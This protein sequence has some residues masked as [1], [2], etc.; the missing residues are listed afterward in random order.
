MVRCP[1]TSSHI[2]LF[3]YLFFHRV[4]SPAGSSLLHSLSRYSRYIGILD[5]DN[6]TLRCPAYKGTLLGH[7]ADHRTQIK[8]GSTYYLHVQSVLTQLAAKAFL[9]TFCHHLYLPI[10]TDQDAGSVV[11]RRTNFLLQLG[12]TE[13][14]SKIIRFLSEL[15]KQH[16]LQGPLKGVS[17]S[18]FSFSYTTSYLYK[19]WIWMCPLFILR[20]F[21]SFHILC[22]PFLAPL[23]KSG[24]QEILTVFDFSS[25]SF[26]ASVGLTIQFVGRGWPV[27]SVVLNVSDD[28]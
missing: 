17:Q 16:Y 20:S 24:D 19:I 14:E 1:Q 11:L 27:I 22:F 13:E 12:Y 28:V 9:Y 4:V 25:L 23:P 2:R 26:S 18:Y 8:R 6:K 10:S 5:C 15:I 3:I 21:N 7:V